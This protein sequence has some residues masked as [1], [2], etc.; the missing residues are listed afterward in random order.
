M[1]FQVGPTT[2]L[3][4]MAQVPALSIHSLTAIPTTFLAQL[5]CQLSKEIKL[6]CLVV[7]AQTFEPHVL[8]HKQHEGKRDPCFIDNDMTSTSAQDPA[9][10]W[11]LVLLANATVSLEK[12]HVCHLL[13]LVIS[14]S[15]SWAFFCF[16]NAFW[17]LK[18]SGYIK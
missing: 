9:C 17:D 10:L 18:K 15:L 16:Q 13:F 6:L 12:E 8:W 11:L 7:A 5:C 1:W 3:A 14:G 4:F 2:M